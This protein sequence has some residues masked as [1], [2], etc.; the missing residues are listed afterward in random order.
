MVMRHGITMM[1]TDVSMGVVEL[2]R[3]AEA[4]GL[5]SLWL[6]EHTHIPVSRR[7]PPPTGTAELAAEYKRCLDPLVAL[8]AVATA[9]ERIRLGTGVLLP[10]QREPIVT[11]K[12]VATLDH[13]SGGRA[14]LGIGFGWNEDEIAQHGVAMADRREVAGE[15]VQ[16]MQALWADDEA[17]FAGTRVAIEPSW[18]WPKPVQTDAAGRRRVPVIHGG[19]AGPKLFGHIAEYGDGWIPIGGAGLTE[20]I[21]RLRA[22]V[23]EAGRDPDALEIIPFSTLPDAGKLDHYERIGVTECVFHLPSA[24]RD[25]V[26]PIL[27]QQA[28]LVAA[29]R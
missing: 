11:A 23:A 9:T 1:A 14:V 25:V 4:R 8:A 29:R 16:A 21:P 10:A 5:D 6:P 15:H 20:A 19:A 27:D 7:T 2:A 13:L 3:E 24:P 18:S 22:V 17:S 28:A 12:A 26:L